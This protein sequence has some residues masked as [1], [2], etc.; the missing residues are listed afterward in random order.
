MTDQ[1]ANNKRI[2]KNTLLLYFR[3]LFTMGVSLYTSRIVLHVLGVDDYGIY[4][5]VGGVVM[6]FAFLS[7][8]MGAASS[9]YITFG[10]GRGDL[11]HLKKVFSSIVSI[12]FCLAILV[13]LLSETVG[14]WFLLHKMQIPP[15]R[16]N[17]AV[18]VYQFSVLTLLTSIMSIP[19]NAVIIA[20]ERMKAFAFISILDVLLKLLGV[21]L[22]VFVAMDKLKLYAGLLFF[23]QLVDQSIYWFYCRR[24]FEESRFRFIWDKPLFREIFV[25]AG[26]T[27][28]GNLAVV[29]YTQGL[30]ILLNLFFGPAV[31]AARGIA[32]Q[33]QG[34]ILRF[35]DNF[36]TALNPQLTKSYAQ[37]ELSYMHQLLV[38]SSK[39]SFFLL[40]FLSMPVM[41]QTEQILNWWLGIV[42]PYTVIFLRLVLLTSMLSALADPVIVSVHATGRL[43]KFQLIEGTM[44]LS[45]VPIAYLLL[46]FAHV[47]PE[48]VFVVHLIVEIFTQ[49][50]RVRIVLPMI[51]M[52]RSVYVK[53]VIYPILKVS[54]I[55]IIVPLLVYLTL[56]VTVGS[57]FILC[58]TCA[59]SVAVT[60]YYGGCT[61]GEREFVMEKIKSLINSKRK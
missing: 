57:F 41:F 50:A 22:L 55:S 33:V 21:Y 18:W 36:Q 1:S 2:A 31:N 10:L 14:L 26:W 34:V 19:Y 25:F 28:N 51:G 5:V 12:H 20:H 7:S 53:K 52:K 38:T 59:G 11:F 61:P 23:I 49:F 24:H 43:K 56:P 13:L 44:L 29:G 3:M 16:V 60:I 17:A 54:L 45:I 9:R 8:S 6:M 37:G 48:S 4:N 42:P 47:P 27:M 35:C 30:N 46:K 39:Y 58:F 15:D 40:I 32:V